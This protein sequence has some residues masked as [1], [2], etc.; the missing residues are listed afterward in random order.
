MTITAQMVKELRE[1]TGVSMM[2]CKNALTES[3]GDQEKAKEILRKK[4]IA[5]AEGR[6]GRDTEEG[7]VATYIH[8]TGK[9][10]AI[11]ALSCE[12]DF[13]ARNEDFRALANEIAMQVA[14]MNP[15]YVSPDDADSEDLEKEKGIFAEQ[16]KKEGKPEQIIEKILE[17]KLKKFKEEGSLLKQKS[18]KN[19]EVTIEDMIK[20][21]IAKMG[22]NITIA[23]FHRME[24]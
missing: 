10:G 21:M 7:Y 12:T 6:S 15:K 8:T 9:L 24:L 13:V 16:L 3:G 22:E 14:A 2:Q 11:V 20:E 19:S 5:K 4:G 18:I 1:E 23:G 17:G